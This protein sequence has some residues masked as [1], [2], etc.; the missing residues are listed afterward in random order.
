MNNL[1][2]AFPEKTEKER[3]KIA[4]KF[5][6]NFTDTFI[7]TIKMISVSDSYVQKRVKGNW[8]VMNKYYESGR[9]VQLFL[10]HNFNW[11]WANLTAPQKVK[12]LFLVVYMPIN[13]KIMDRLFYKLRSRSGSTLLPATKMREAFLPYRDL[14]Y[15]LTLV[16]DQNPGNPAKAWWFDF[17]GKPAPFVKGPEKGAKAK[18]TVVVFAFIH[19]IRRGH[20]EI[21]FSVA[22]E[23]PGAL[24]EKALTQ[25]FVRYLEDVIRQY[26]DMWLWSHRRWKHEW[27]PE[28]GEIIK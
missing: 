11:E 10:G 4:R 9:S 12:Y 7:E 22:D 5:Y 20:Y 19:K 23:D 15:I 26:P 25:K 6:F 18:N 14:Q 3:I 24:P 8:D 21:V 16:A 17:L 27:I 1:R 2:Q 13:S 28:Y